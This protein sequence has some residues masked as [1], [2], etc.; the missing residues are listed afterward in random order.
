MSKSTSFSI[1]ENVSSRFQSSI[2]LTSPET[3]FITD[4]W[5]PKNF[6]NYILP[7]RPDQFDKRI[8]LQKACFTF[9][10]PAKESVTTQENDSLLTFQIPKDAKPT[11]KE[12]LFLLGI[13]SFSV[14]G[15]L[16]DL[17][18]RLKQAYNIS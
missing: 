9:H 17:A 7:I 5:D 3:Y 14:Y 11:L 16:D 4:W 2:V 13:D 6:P 18:A 15:D 12:E 8:M 10:P 1:S